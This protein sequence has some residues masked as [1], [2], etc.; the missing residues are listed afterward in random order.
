MS[1]TMMGPPQVMT[2]GT[3]L[4]ALVF[5]KINRRAPSARHRNTTSF[6]MQYAHNAVN[7]LRP[8]NNSA[9]DGRAQ[10]NDKHFQNLSLPGSE[11]QIQIPGTVSKVEKLR[12]DR[13]QISFCY[14]SLYRC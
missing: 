7:T 2:S 12:C 13:G 9:E 8:T 6:D 11:H 3:A 10:A 14:V 4:G 5:E 1:E